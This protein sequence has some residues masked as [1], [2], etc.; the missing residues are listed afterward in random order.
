MYKAEFVRFYLQ[1]FNEIMFDKA[2]YV[3]QYYI[4]ATRK[5]IIHSL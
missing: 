5:L 2:D 1:N 4:L 3:I